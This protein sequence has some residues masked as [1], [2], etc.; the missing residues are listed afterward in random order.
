MFGELI[1]LSSKHHYKEICHSTEEYI[2]DEPVMTY[3]FEVEILFK[4]TSQK[5]CKVRSAKLLGLGIDLVDNNFNSDPELVE[6]YFKASF[7]DPLEEYL[8]FTDGLP[9]FP[10]YRGTEIRTTL[11]F[12]FE[13]MSLHYTNAKKIIDDLQRYFDNPINLVLS[14][15]LYMEKFFKER[16]VSRISANFTSYPRSK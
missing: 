1:V 13:Y 11:T 2:T 16:F 14:L 15:D 3:F 5:P 6:R 8:R 4:N 9:Q 12:S 10:L 7:Y